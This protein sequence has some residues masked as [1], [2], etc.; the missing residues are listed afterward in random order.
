MWV[1]K[2]EPKPRKVVRGRRSTTKPM[3]A[4]FFGKTGHVATVPLEQRMTV[5]SELKTTI[6]LPLTHQLK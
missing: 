6:C 1:F 5:N 2:G 3:I 4:C